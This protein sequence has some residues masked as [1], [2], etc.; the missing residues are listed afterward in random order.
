MRIVT[1]CLV[2]LVGAAGSGKSTWVALNF[3]PHEIVSSDELRAVAGIDENDQTASTDAFFLL[4]EIVRRRLARRLTTVIDTTGLDAPSR[5]GYRDLARSK[6]MST[7][8]VAFDTPAALCH[9]RNQLRTHPIPKAVLNRQLSAYKKTRID[10]ESEEFDGLIVI[11]PSQ[12]KVAL[13]KGP[14]AMATADAGAR[15]QARQP[16][17][18]RFGLQVSS[19][20]WPDDSSTTRQHLTTIATA[21][22]AAGFESLWLMDHFRQIP[23]VGRAWDDMLEPYVTLAFLAGV[24]TEIRLGALVTAVGYRNPALLGK[25]LATLDVLTEGRA[26]CGLGIGWFEQEAR[27]YGY[28]F[29]EAAV[30]YELLE[31]ALRLL[32]LLWGPGSPAY[33]GHHIDV[34]EAMGYPRPIQDPIPIVVGGSG[35]RRTLRLV[36]EYADYCN[37]F[38]DPDTVRSKI[39]VLA[40]HCR[41]VERDPA[42]I[43]VSHLGSCLVGADQEHVT[44]LLDHHRPR[45][46][47]RAQF[48]EISKAGTVVEQIGRYRLLADAGVQLAIVTMPNV[49][50]PGAIERFGEVIAAFS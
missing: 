8:V 18:L 36:A 2:I 24:T 26:M 16:V 28:D 9:T 43:V 44:S 3:A 29:P 45:T 48:A 38:G 23:Q 41:A 20:R 5:A 19:F 7:Y 35:E 40:D 10:I 37:L 42:E 1:P 46:M 32:P 47:D 34:P 50:E 39:A 30:R 31:D 25:M 11:E 13:P 22:E 14:P 33:Y 6:D 12:D 27:A 15:N 17:G 4:D 49:A 21:A